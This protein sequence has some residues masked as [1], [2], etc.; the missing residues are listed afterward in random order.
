MTVVDDLLFKGNRIVVPTVLQPEILKRLH[1]GHMGMEKTKR[2]ARNI[3]YWPNM[4]RDIDEMISQCNTCV[5]FRNQ[6]PTEP[7]VSTPI[8]DGPWQTVGTDLF[9]LHESD[10]LVVTDYY[11]KF[12]EVVKLPNTQSRTVIERLR[13]IFA[14]NGIP[15]EVISDNGTQYTS[16]EFREFAQKWNFQHT[17]SSPY[18]QRA[19]ELAERT[20]QTAERLLEKPNTDGKDPYLGLLEYRNT[21]TDTGLPAQLLMCRELRFILPITKKRLRP[22]TINR[23]ETYKQRARSQHRQQ[24]YYNRTT[25][26]QEEIPHGHKV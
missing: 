23:T 1:T 22:K 11:S 3:I 13:S 16:Q 19:N 9:T 4:N 14:R 17:T 7:F 15:F 8:P 18:H 25:K 12:F 6:N 26:S 24:Y 10:C 21:P 20:V 2:R 5:D